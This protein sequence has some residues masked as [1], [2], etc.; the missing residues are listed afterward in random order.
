M[1]LV[2]EAV[3][4]CALA[5]RESRGAHSRIDYPNY[6]ETWAK[7]NNIISKRGGQMTLEQRPVNEMPAELK[8]LLAEN[9]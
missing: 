1:V 4:R 8:E 5:R 3:T 2:S 9:K 6:D 7:R